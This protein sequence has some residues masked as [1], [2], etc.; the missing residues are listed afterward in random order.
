MTSI[1]INLLRLVYG[2]MYELVL[3]M[4]YV[5]LRIMCSVL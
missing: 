1:P 3:K 2:L 5:P 4:S